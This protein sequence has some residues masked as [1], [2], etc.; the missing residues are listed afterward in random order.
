MMPRDARLGFVLGIT[1]VIL[2]AVIFYHGDGKAGPAGNVG[3]VGVAREEATPKPTVAPKPASLRTHV[4][5]EGETL[6]S[7]AVKYYDDPERHEL[8]YRA[9]RSQMTA[10]GRVWVGMVLVIPDLPGEKKQ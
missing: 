6:T 10:Q 8:L 3:P 9:N 2:V 4:V 5:Q 7:I 1:M